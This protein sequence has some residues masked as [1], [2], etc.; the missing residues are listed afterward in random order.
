[1]ESIAPSS[2]E[3]IR[4]Y[5]HLYRA[6]LQAVQYSAPNR[7]A[8]RD[9]LRIAFRRG[10]PQEFDQQKISRTLEFIDGARRETGLEHRLLRSLLATAFRRTTDVKL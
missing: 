2:S 1:M 6:L 8:A 3:V 10:N 5:R 9:Q 4:A 7:I